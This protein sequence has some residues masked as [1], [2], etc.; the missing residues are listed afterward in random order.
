MARAHGE[1]AWRGHAPIGASWCALASNDLLVSA[2][3]YRWNRRTETVRRNP[4]L[5]RDAL[6][7]RRKRRCQTR[8]EDGT[9]A[10]PASKPADIGRPDRARRHG[11]APGKWWRGCPRT[12]S[13]LRDARDRQ[14]PSVCAGVV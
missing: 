14:Q 1:E 7:R 3:A 9:P 2:A 10:V 4:R 5:G 6:R 13:T 12:S 11:W 8:R